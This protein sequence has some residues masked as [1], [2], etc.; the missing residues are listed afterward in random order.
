MAA[1][2]INGHSDA[3]APDKPPLMRDRRRRCVAASAG[4]VRIPRRG[5]R[6]SKDPA[7]HHVVECRFSRNSVLVFAMAAELS[8]FNLFSMRLEPI[9]PPTAPGLQVW[10]VTPP[11]PVQAKDLPKLRMRLDHGK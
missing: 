9:N 3:L 1:Q 4:K 5:L 10:G 2:A 8:L 7:E 6:P 11:S